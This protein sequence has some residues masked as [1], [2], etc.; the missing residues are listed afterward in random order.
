MVEKDPNLVRVIS[1]T[2][3]EQLANNREINQDI[4]LASGCIFSITP[5]LF[6]LAREPQMD[7]TRLRDF[8]P[9]DERD[10]N[11]A[12]DI[13]I[14]LVK[15]LVNEANCHCYA[16]VGR[17]LNRGGVFLNPAPMKKKKFRSF[18]KFNSGA[19]RHRKYYTKTKMMEFLHQLPIERRGY[20]ILASLKYIIEL[21]HL[22]EDYVGEV[23]AEHGITIKMEE[24]RKMGKSRP[25]CAA[26]EWPE[27]I[28]NFLKLPQIST[29]LDE[30]M[31]DRYKL[32]YTQ[33]QIYDFFKDSNPNFP[34]SE[35]VFRDC[36]SPSFV[37]VKAKRIPKK[38][39][40]QQTLE[41]EA[42]KAVYTILLDPSLSEEC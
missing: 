41:K 8:L 1:K 36:F 32:K 6:H 2:A 29:P 39:Q 12:L 35:T 9:Q 7:K 3:Y 30:G 25:C 20:A 17:D 21:S 24:T 22:K 19:E 15:S 33:R 26:S 4:Y 27:K 10:S 16:V 13:L 5:G 28:L 34:Y 18:W 23:F 14:G 31:S 37:S 42:T 11:E 38:N 40:Q